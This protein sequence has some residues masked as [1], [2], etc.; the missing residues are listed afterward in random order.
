MGNLGLTKDHISIEPY[1]FPYLR[2]NWPSDSQDSPYDPL[3]GFPNGR[4]TREMDSAKLHPKFRDYCAHKYIEYYGCLKNNR[5]LYWRC[6][7]ERH[8]YG[9]CEFQDTVLR[10][11]EWERERRLRERELRRAQLEAA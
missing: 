2:K 11:K 5:P 6:K 3:E 1:T 10:M 7:H 8:E 9:E 4:K